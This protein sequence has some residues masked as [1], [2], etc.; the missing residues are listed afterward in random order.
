MCNNYEQHVAWE[1]Y[2]KMMQDLEWGI[3]TQQ[4]ERDL[5]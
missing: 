5:Q 2:C 1:A 4:S 3:P